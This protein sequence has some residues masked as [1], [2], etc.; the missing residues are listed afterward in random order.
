MC[1]R[2]GHLAL[3]ALVAT[4]LCGVGAR[5]A[6]AQAPEPAEK[7]ASAQ[8]PAP[9][10]RISGLVFGDYY[11]FA[12]DHDERFDGQSGFWLRRG[13]LTYDH[14][15]APN[16]ATRFRLEVNSNGRMAGGS[17]TPFLKDAYLRWNYRGAHQAFIGMQP[18][19][20][21]E[22]IDGVWGLRYVE[23]VPADLYRFDSTR[24]LG[25]GFTGPVNR[26]GTIRY[27]ALVGNDSGTGSETDGKMAVRLSARY[28]TNPGIFLE[29]SYWYADRPMGADRQAVQ[30]FAA[31]RHARGRVGLNY[32]WHERK[33]AANDLPRAETTVVSAFAVL[34]LKPRKVSVF[35]RLDR[36]VDPPA[37]A[38]VDYL[39]ISTASPFTFGLLGAEYR[40]TSSVFFSP[41]AEF[42]RYGTPERPTVAR[43]RN[44]VVL[45][46]SF[47]WVW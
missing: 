9:A 10:W 17:L 15:L 25:V 24:D 21:L 28:D 47:H 30:A 33:Q 41:N 36:A 42:V 26:A 22:V 3:V 40:L 31:Y 37:D 7:P 45:R 23:K 13:Y 11:Y 39:P 34:D 8:P 6:F 35:A 27:S 18:T 12:Q 46:A 44:D 43:P 5:R 2:V 16:L 1:S 20:T 19:P 32:V 38:T 29:G 14:N 4:A